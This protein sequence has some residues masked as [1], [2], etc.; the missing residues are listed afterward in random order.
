MGRA[1]VPTVERGGVRAH[2][3]A[4][5]SSALKAAWAQAG[6]GD[7]DGL[8]VSADSSQR[9]HSLTGNYN[10]LLESI[11]HQSPNIYQTSRAGLPPGST[12]LCGLSVA[13]LRARLGFAQEFGG[14][15]AGPHLKVSLPHL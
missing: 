8:S 13:C 4:S 3:L 10:A 6:V 2:C 9:V 1:G 15:G 14:H 5:P 7:G 11:S 12:E